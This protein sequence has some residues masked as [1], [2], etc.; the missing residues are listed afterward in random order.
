MGVSRSERE[1]TK[2]RRSIPILIIASFQDF[3]T[4]LV[5]SI[6]KIAEDELDVNQSLLSSSRGKAAI[7]IEGVIDRSGIYQE[8]ETH[9]K[10]LL[11]DHVGTI[12]GG[13]RAIRREDIGEEAAEVEEARGSK[14]DDQYAEDA[15]TRRRDRDKVREELREK[16]RAIAEERRK[17]EKARKREEERKREAEEDKRR[18]EREA[19]RKLEREAERERERLRTKDM[20]RGRDYD[21]DRSRDGGRRKRQ[22]GSRDA[23]D[24]MAK[25]NLSREEVD[26]LEQEALAMLMKEGKR[27]SQRSRHQME[28]E[29]DETL[30]PP[31]RKSMPSSAIKPISRDAPTKPMETKKDLGTKL[32]HN[33]SNAFHTSSHTIDETKRDDR[34]KRIRARS[35]SRDRDYSH[36]D[37]RDR[38]GHSRRSSRDRDDR[39]N[40][41]RDRVDAKDRSKPTRRDSRDRDD[42]RPRDSR[43][44]DDRR[45]RDSRDRENRS[46]KDNRVRD[47]RHERDRS[48]NPRDDRRSYRERDSTRDSHRRSRSRTPPPRREFKTAEEMK[49]EAVK[50]RELEAKAYLAAQ[51]EAREKGL[52]I[53]GFDKPRTDGGFTKPNWRGHRD[54]NLGS[55]KRD[56]E[57][58]GLSSSTLPRKKEFSTDIGRDRD[59]AKRDSSVRSPSRASSAK[60]ERSLSHDTRRESVSAHSPTIKREMAP[61]RDVERD[62]DKDSRRHRDPSRRRSRSRSRSRTRRRDRSKDAGRDRN[63]VRSRSRSHGKRKDDRRG[64]SRSRERDSTK[65]YRSRSRNHEREKDDRRSSRVD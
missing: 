23:R 54:E 38:E 41:S 9:I 12:E 3:E 60:H 29:V 61:S 65:R 34:D 24:P 28:P 44:Y 2:S 55:R 43:D 15:A 8:A 57:T 33:A 39:R 31:P 37:S 56:A 27:V 13:I 64:R 59:F 40:R 18:E 7:L 21:R 26:R 10:K 32:D 25:S 36:R 16:E 58:A 1:Y 47:S 30:A 5:A 49:Q 14:T 52:P 63:S 11:Q 50:K 45:R 51:K 62:N 6:T 17:L 35:R 53:P 46:G 20:D 19:R 22:D 4:Q 48:R 42:R